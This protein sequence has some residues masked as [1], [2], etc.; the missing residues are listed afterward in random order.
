M[1]RQRPPGQSMF[2]VHWDRPVKG[3][4]S[5][6]GPLCLSKDSN[7]HKQIKTNAI[8]FD[9]LHKCKCQMWDL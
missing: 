6:I 3:S 4:S 7:M 2:S 5:K 8:N 1:S 9:E